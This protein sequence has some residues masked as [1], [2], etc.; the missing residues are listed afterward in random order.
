MQNI[1]NSDADKFINEDNARKFKRCYELLNTV[2]DCAESLLLYCDNDC[3]AFTLIC[4]AAG[5]P[6]SATQ[7]HNLK[8]GFKDV[9]LTINF[10]VKL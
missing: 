9:E 5:I 4:D 3:T 10:R 7:R 1:Y 8:G 2:R 6:W